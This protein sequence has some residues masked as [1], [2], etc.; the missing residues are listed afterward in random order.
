MAAADRARVIFS[1]T[2]Q[3]V[4]FRYTTANTAR[5]FP[6]VTGRVKNLPDGT[7]ELIAEGTRAEVEAFI[8]A[9]SDRMTGYI[10]N[11]DIQWSHSECQYPT[12]GIG[13]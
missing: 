8:A 3:G 11:A 7:V 1:G 12:F 2:V 4:G 6:A 13:Y 9:I 10:R 5:R